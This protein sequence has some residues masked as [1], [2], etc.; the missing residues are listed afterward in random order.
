MTEEVQAEIPA[1]EVVYHRPAIADHDDGFQPRRLQNGVSQ[2]HAGGE[3][4]GASMRGVDRVQ[5]RKECV[6]Q[7]HADAEAGR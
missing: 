5:V 1:A 7:A 6:R 3:C 4:R 2:G